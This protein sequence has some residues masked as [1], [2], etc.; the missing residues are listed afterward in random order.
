VRAID[1][2]E[3][4][5][6]KYGS[7]VYVRHEIVHN[8]H[9]VE[10]LKGKGAI[11][12]EELDEVPE[13]ARTVFSAHGVPLSVVEQAKTRGLPVLDA[14]CPLVTK[15]HMQGKRYVS[16]GRT[17][18]LIGHAG[19]PEVE[20]TMGQVGAPVHLVSTEADVEKLD[21]AQ[22]TP[23]AYVTQTT[24]SVDDTKGVIAA[25]KG[26]FTDITGPD[27]SD[28]CYATQHRQQAVRDLCKVSDVIL[29]VGAANSS[30]SN[31]LR[32]I[33]VEEGLP[34]DLIADGDEL[35]PEWVRGVETVGLTAGASA[36]EEL[37]QSVI[38]ALRRLGKVEVS[39]MD[40]IV[41]NIEFRLPG[42][43][44]N[45]VEVA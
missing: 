5:L 37:I 32:E 45:H 13:G 31:R 44:R 35:N 41:E 15:V 34:S 8:R 1:I 27:T 22:D 43:L 14:T 36:P 7:P 42:E 40:G 10:K 24:L 21:F 29:V 19:H 17:L 3:R 23:L 12:V 6:E 9:V 20:G 18:I 33:G 38:D 26:R 11:F 25:L 2:V 16:R 4:A 28:I 39:T 30:N